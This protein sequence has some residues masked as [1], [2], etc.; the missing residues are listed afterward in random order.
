ML[1]AWIT[2]TFFRHPSLLSIASGRSSRLHPVSAQKCCILVRADHPAFAHSCGGVHRSMSLMSTSIL[3]QQCPAYLVHV[4][5]IVFVMGGRWPYSCCSICNTEHL[6]GWGVLPLCRDAAC[7]FCSPTQL[8][9]KNC[10]IL[11]AEQVYTLNS[12]ISNNFD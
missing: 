12:S 3:L 9:C 6:L 1:P 8:S 5:L 10:S 2:L 7:I 11:L 4:T